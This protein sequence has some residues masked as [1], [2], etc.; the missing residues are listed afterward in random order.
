VAFDEHE[1]VPTITT[2]PMWRRWP[3]SVFPAAELELLTARL[4]TTR[5]CQA[6]V[7]DEVLWQ[8]VSFAGAAL[9]AAG[10]RAGA[11]ATAAD[12]ATQRAASRTKNA[13]TC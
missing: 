8:I 11:I 10:A 5:R 13:F 4:E 6:F 12:A 9:A 3:H 1:A 7:A 2:S